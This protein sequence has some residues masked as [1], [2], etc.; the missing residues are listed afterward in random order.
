[1]NLYLVQTY[2]LL[3]YADYY[4]VAK[5]ETEARKL[6]FNFYEKAGHTTV[7]LVA[8]KI[9][10]LAS[11]D[12]HSHPVEPLILAIDNELNKI[13]ADMITNEIWEWWINAK[14]SK[15]LDRSRE[16]FKGIKDN[17]IKWLE[18]YTEKVSKS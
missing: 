2:Q 11:E 13:I 9:K 14:L 15:D 17:I 10:W 1:M 6:V 8:T 7:D 12:T 3:S 16:E 18:E 4:V 5:N